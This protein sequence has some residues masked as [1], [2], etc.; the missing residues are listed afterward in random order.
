MDDPFS[1]LKETLKS[2]FHFEP[3]RNGKFVYH[4][5]QRLKDSIE[6][7]RADEKE[8]LIALINALRAA[9]PHIEKWNIN[10]DAIKKSIDSLAKI[11][12]IPDVNWGNALVHPNASPRFSFSASENTELIHWLNNLSEKKL[13]QADHEIDILDALITH[14]EVFGFGRKLSFKLKEEPEFLLQF[15]M[16]SEDDFNKVLNNRL[17]FYLTDAQIAEAIIKYLPDFQKNQD[18]IIQ[19]EEQINKLNGILSN[20]GRSVFTL[21]RNASAKPIL[22]TSSYFK[23]Y[24]SDEYQ[25]R[26]ERPSLSPSE[27]VSKPRI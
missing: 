7:Y 14:G 8:T 1:A 23:I 22:D 16:R 17:A 9:L 12:Q 27:D 19:V 18:T 4:E 3:I 2:V 13:G 15:I 24:Q 25:N 20:S 5:I 26:H 10:F 6:N 21:L 11:H